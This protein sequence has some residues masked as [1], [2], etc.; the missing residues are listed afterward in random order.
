MARIATTPSWVPFYDFGAGRMPLF[1]QE[2]AEQNQSRR[3]LTRIGTLPSGLSG[4][5][6]LARRGV[7]R[8]G[9]FGWARTSFGVA[10][11]RLIGTPLAR[12]AD[13]WE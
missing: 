6:R 7:A 1:P 9:K 5:P 3:G 4:Y 13:R 12:L 2:L 10:P 8:R 11:W